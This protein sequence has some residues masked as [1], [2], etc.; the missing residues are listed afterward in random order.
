MKN[1]IWKNWNVLTDKIAYPYEIFITI[2]EYNLPDNKINKEDFLYI[3]Q[4]QQLA[5]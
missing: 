5:C 2:E 4:I 1:K 3:K